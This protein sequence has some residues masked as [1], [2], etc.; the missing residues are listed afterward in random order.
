M[1]PGQALAASAQDSQ[2]KLQ[3]LERRPLSARQ[4]HHHQLG[5]RLHHDALASLQ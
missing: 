1:E 2:A 4:L 5:A 3:S